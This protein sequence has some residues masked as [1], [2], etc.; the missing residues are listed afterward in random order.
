MPNE[1]LEENNLE[2]EVMEESLGAVELSKGGEKLDA[3]SKGAI[4]KWKKWTKKQAPR[5]E[6]SEVNKKLEVE[7]GKRHLVDVM[8][9]DGTREMEGKWEKKLKGQDMEKINCENEPELRII[10]SWPLLLVLRS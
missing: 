7:I 9:I 4:V 5:K 6:M 1:M 3:T 10:L 8:I 2:I